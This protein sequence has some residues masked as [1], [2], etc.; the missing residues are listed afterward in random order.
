MTKYI[1]FL[2]ILL[3]P[4]I[5]LAREK[6]L[7]KKAPLF[8]ADAVFPDGSRETF[9]LKNYQGR[10]VVL[11]FYPRD[12]SPYCTLQAQNFKDNFKSLQAHDII[13]IG[14]SPDSIQAH[15]KFQCSLQLPYP[16]VADVSP[17]YAI[18]KQY[19]AQGFL[20][21][22]RKTFL[23]NKQGIIFKIFNS[24]VIDTQTHDILQ[25]FHEE[26]QKPA[27]K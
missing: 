15:T 22:Q 25:A 12:N 18:A 24:V 6:L 11:Y 5:F 1:L 23:I 10:N 4:M 2:S 21:G 9:D 14:I 16:L 13:V 19:Q 27:H 26:W 8:T 17:K 7:H 20:F 3:F